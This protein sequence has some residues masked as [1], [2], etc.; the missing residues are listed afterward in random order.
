M[1]TRRPPVSRKVSDTLRD[2]VRDTRDGGR[3]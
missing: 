1:I 3:T 2:T